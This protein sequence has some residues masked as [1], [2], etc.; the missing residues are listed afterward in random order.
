MLGPESPST[1]TTAVTG[2]PP[3]YRLWLCGQDADALQPSQTADVS[4]KRLSLLV[5]SLHFWVSVISAK[6]GNPSGNQCL[7]LQNLTIHVHTYTHIYMCIHSKLT[8]IA[9]GFVSCG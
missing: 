1:D 8:S 2:E 5:S 3:V 6:N 4:R 7:A 9:T